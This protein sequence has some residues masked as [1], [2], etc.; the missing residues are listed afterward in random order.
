[1]KCSERNL[2]CSTEG[3]DVLLAHPK[4]GFYRLGNKTKAFQ[5]LEPQERC[6]PE[7]WKHNDLKSD[8]NLRMLHTDTQ[9]V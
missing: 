7:T 8:D 1:M 2:E 5:C 3:S 9:S 6:S 4:S